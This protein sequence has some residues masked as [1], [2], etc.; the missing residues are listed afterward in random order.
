[1]KN[2]I[3]NLKAESVGAVDTH[4]DTLQNDGN[5]LF[6]ERFSK[7]KKA[8]LEIIDALFNMQKIED[9]NIKPVAI[10]DTG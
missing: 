10:L 1:M 6:N 7:I 9:R 2:N 3:I 5:Y 4:T 8:I